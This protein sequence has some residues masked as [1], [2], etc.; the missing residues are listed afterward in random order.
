IS[1][2][3]RR[4]N[5]TDSEYIRSEIEQYMIEKDCEECRGN[6]LKKDVLAVTIRGKNIID[7]G[8]M[9]IKQALDWIS[10][11]NEEPKV[12]IENSTLKELFN[13][14]SIDPKE[15]DLTNQEK[16]IAKQII[17]EITSRLGFL[18]SVGLEYLTLN[19]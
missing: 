10:N 4:Y 1:N 7:I 16:E 17:K 14:N 11:L 13:L 5:E 12:I 18:N 6:R 8:N 15:D 2:L 3:M 9:T 19:R